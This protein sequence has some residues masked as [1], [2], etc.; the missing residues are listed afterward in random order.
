MLA[1]ALA[2]FHVLH[3]LCASR[4]KRHIDLVAA[5]PSP[6]VALFRRYALKRHLHPLGGLRQP[7]GVVDNL[8]HHVVARRLLNRKRPVGK[9]RVA[10]AEA[11]ILQIE[12]G[13]VFGQI[14]DAEVGRQLLLRVDR[15]DRG[16][17]AAGSGGGNA[18]QAA[19]GG[20]CEVGREVGHHDKAIR[21]RHLRILVVG[22]DRCILVA[23]ILLNHKLHLLCDVGEPLLDLRGLSPDATVHQQLVVVSQMHETSE[24]FAET[25][26]ID[27]R[28]PGLAGRDACGDPQ[29][30]RLHHLR[31]HVG[32]AG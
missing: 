12:D 6:P 18:D 10:P 25:D 24:V 27:D 11:A 21:L 26:W 13:G 4:A 14:V 20:F 16:N 9:L 30:H 31:R 23:E 28:K 32:L 19:G 17:A 15:D 5:I 1:R 2:K 22:T 7:A 8:R 3:L 29:H